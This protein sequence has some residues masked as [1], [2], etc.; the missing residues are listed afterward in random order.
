LILIRFFL[1]RVLL[2]LLALSP[3]NASANSELRRLIKEKVLSEQEVFF[4]L[5]AT[6]ENPPSVIKKFCLSEKCLFSEILDGHGQLQVRQA[7]AS[8]TE[9]MQH[10]FLRY[11]VSFKARLRIS[12]T[13]GFSGV[14]C[15]QQFS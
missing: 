11:L 2:H 13:N 6:K 9:S 15:S 14:S 8:Q 1:V 3:N 5:L 4:S 12:L 7:F 10:W